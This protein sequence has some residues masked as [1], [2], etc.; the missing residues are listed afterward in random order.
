[1][2]EKISSPQIAV[3]SRTGSRCGSGGG[4]GGVVVA[5][6]AVN[7]SS[8]A[9]RKLHLRG[10]VGSCH[11]LTD[12]VEMASQNRNRKTFAVLNVTGKEPEVS[13]REL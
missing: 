7:L 4:G 9:H 13:S 10:E 5:A 3:P 12:G 6:E 11:T 2:V 8:S 1:M